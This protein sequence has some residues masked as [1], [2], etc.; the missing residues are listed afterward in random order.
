MEGRGPSDPRALQPSSL[1]TLDRPF[2]VPA[3][4]LPAAPDVQLCLLAA[5]RSAASPYILHVYVQ[6]L[7]FLNF[8]SP[9]SAAAEVVCRV[10]FSCLDVRLY[11]TRGSKA[12]V[13]RIWG[14]IRV[15]L[16]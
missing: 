16:G 1:A 7:E 10:C 11:L 2:S 8:G 4:N 5:I 9:A 12:N 3:S 14:F 13:G 6:L 15:I